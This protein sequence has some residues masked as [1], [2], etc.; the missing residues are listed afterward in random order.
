MTEDTVQSAMYF[1]APNN[2]PYQITD[3]IYNFYETIYEHIPSMES[4]KRST[5]RLLLIGTTRN[6][7]IHRALIFL[8]FHLKTLQVLL[9]ASASV[10]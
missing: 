4:S 9:E 8:P 3:T 6:H 5:S 1:F 2:V 10:S 7:F